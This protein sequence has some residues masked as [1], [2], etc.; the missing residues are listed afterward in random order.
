MERVPDQVVDSVE[1]DAVSEPVFAVR[2]RAGSGDEGVRSVLEAFVT[3][4]RADGEFLLEGV[5]QGRS[6]GTDGRAY[7]FRDVSGQ[8]GVV[9]EVGSGFSVLVSEDA[10]ARLMGRL[11]RAL[12]Q[13]SAAQVQE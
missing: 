9:I 13:A 1:V 5:R 4:S 7:A 2:G 8:D 11:Q 6:R 3:V 12:D 10:F